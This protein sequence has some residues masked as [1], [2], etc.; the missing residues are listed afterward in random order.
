MKTSR[1]KLRCIIKEEILKVH[2]AITDLSFSRV[3]SPTSDNTVKKKDKSKKEAVQGITSSGAHKYARA[4][5]RKKDKDPDSLNNHSRFR[6]FL[7]D[8]LKTY[9]PS[10]DI[11]DIEEEIE[12]WLDTNII[13]AEP[14][15][16]KKKKSTRKKKSK[17]TRKKK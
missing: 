7:S 1:S 6:N 11:D 14:T 15:Q 12:D 13:D 10:T 4:Y 5:L 9:W 16:P 8:N 3:S 2:E 17:K